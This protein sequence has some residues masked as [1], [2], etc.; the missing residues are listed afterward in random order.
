MPMAKKPT[1]KELE[2]TVEELKNAHEQLIIYA[3][4]LKGEI[5]DHKK[6][7]TALAEERERFERLVE[8]SPDGVILIQDRKILLTN[9]SFVEMLGYADAKDLVGMEMVEFFD[10]EFR[11]LFA[12]VFD[13]RAYDKDFEPLQ[14]GICMCQNGRKIWVST[15]SSVITWKKGPAILTAI[16][17][18]TEDVQREAAIQEEAENFRKENIKLR[19]SIKE[20]YRF[21][22][23]IGKSAPMQKVYELILKAAAT[24]ANIIILGESGTGKELVASAIHE[25]S[26]RV[27]KAFVTVNCG[28]I[29]ENLIESEFFGHR[30]GAFTGA[31]S[32]KNGYFHAADKGTL[33][34][35]EVGEIGLN[36]QVKLLRVLET[37]EY[38]PVGDTRSRKSDIRIVFATNRNPSDMVEAGLMRED[39]YYRISVIPI[40]LPPLRERKEDLPLLIEH[41]LQSHST[42][43]KPPAIPGKIMDVMNNYDWPGNVRELLSVIRRYLVLGDISLLEIGGKADKLDPGSGDGSIGPVG[44]LDETLK[45]QE[46]RFILNALNQH[47]WH[48]G[49]TAAALKIDPKTL[50]TK[51]KKFGIS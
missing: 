2:Q 48:K 33:F 51:M 19:S 47:R 38:T 16:R 27:D 30:K 26:D 12:K 39:F 11:D 43:K 10:V 40:N 45:K 44:D 37:G 6:A 29:S 7:K 28:A 4:E 22:R 46:K 41:F 18:I 32:D 13:S 15:K 8:L 5:K 49:K 20:R 9:H 34:L 31:D 50:Y 36:M 21:G 14:R 23:L 35:D 42:D 17:D 3:K 1:I 24:D 25:M